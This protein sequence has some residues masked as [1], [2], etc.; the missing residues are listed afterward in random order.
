MTALLA[1]FLAVWTPYGHGILGGI[2]ALIIAV[3]CLALLLYVIKAC[4][5]A[6]GWP[7]PPPIWKL[8]CLL[9]LVI[10]VIYAISA[11]GFGS[12]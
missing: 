5:E 10:A 9:A 11:F 1:T 3:I 8:L 7:I 12:P 2:V 6:L 4:A